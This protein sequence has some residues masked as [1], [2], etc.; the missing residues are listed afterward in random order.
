MRRKCRII[1]GNF[2]TGQR[3]MEVGETGKWRNIRDWIQL[4]QFMHQ[5]YSM[6]QSPS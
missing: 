2:E 1:A 6:Q 4:S 3:D 5:N